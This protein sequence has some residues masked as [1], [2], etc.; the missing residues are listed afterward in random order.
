MHDILALT[1]C[2]GYPRILDQKCLMYLLPGDP[3]LKQDQKSV[4]MY[5]LGPRMAQLSL[6]RLNWIIWSFYLLCK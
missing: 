2:A 1:I 3:A 6:H 5:V 4:T